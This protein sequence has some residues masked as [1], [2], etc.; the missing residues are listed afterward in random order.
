MSPLAAEQTELLRALARHG[1]S[2]WSWAVSRP[3]STAG[4]ARLPTSTSL[5][6][7]RPCPDLRVD[8]HLFGD[9]VTDELDRDLLAHGLAPRLQLVR[10]SAAQRLE[11]GEHLLHLAM[12][13]LEHLDHVAAA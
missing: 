1:V 2:S 10:R 4:G 9:G 11:L 7:P 8:E 5:C 6:P 3:R 12:V 13:L